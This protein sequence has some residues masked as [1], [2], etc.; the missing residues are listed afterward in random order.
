MKSDVISKDVE[1]WKFQDE[2][3]K[4]NIM[5][6][7]YNNINNPLKDDKRNEVIHSRQ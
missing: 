7:I 6:N 5:Y 2:K 1:R 3:A 4:R